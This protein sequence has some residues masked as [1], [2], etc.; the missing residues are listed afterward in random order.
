M[1]CQIEVY[2]DLIYKHFVNIKII[3]GPFVGGQKV[4]FHC[5]YE[6]KQI[7]LKIVF[8]PKSDNSL[9][10]T[11]AED[12]I[13]RELRIMRQVDSDHFVRLINIPFRKIKNDDGLF[14]MYAEEWIAGEPV[15]ELL[16]NQSLGYKDAVQIGLDIGNAI[17]VLWQNKIIHRDIKPEN[18]IR[19]DNGC[20]VLL[21]LGIAYDLSASSLT[22]I[23]GHPGTP[24]YMSP[25][26]LL[27]DDK[28]KLDFRSDLYSLGIVMYEVITGINPVWNICVKNKCNL[29]TYFQ[30]NLKPRHILELEPN[31]NKNLASI[32]MRLIQKRPNLRYRKMEFFTGML[33]KIQ[34]EL[35]A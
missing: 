2:K 34:E 17:E 9:L 25:E 3:G 32:V 1:E 14:F 6:G 18:I 30:S 10:D 4:V 24:M 21:D 27:L 5:L 22:C 33:M 29:D 11:S 20:Y 7:A 19:R 16:R 26:Q 23:G 13:M 15:R 12:R 8:V 35:E 28:R 31:L